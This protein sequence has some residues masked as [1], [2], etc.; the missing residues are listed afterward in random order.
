MGAP[1]LYPFVLTPAIERKLTLID[2]LVRKA[3]TPS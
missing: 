3:D 1:D 2:Q